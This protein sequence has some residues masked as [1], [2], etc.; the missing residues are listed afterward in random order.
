MGVAV[1]IAL[2]GLLMVTL[3]YAVRLERALGRLRV[4]RSAMQDAVLGFDAGARQAEVGVG[5]L[6]EV[7][8][9]LGGT[10]GQATALRDDLAFLHERGERLADRLDTLVRA[11][12]AV[13]T[14]PP[15]VAVRGAG[16]SLRSRAE[17]SL[18]VALQGRR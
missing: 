8:D 14:E 13:E 3:V 1:E 11:A 16:S 12:R 17:R 18:L 10:M 5:R 6:R 9:Q 15:E 4:D 7:A 2:M